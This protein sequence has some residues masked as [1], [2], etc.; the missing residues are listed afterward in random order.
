M[1]QFDKVFLSILGILA[2]AFC[3]I[4]GTIAYDTFFNKSI[5]NRRI[6]CVQGYEFT[7]DSTGHFHQIIDK[8][9]NGIPCTY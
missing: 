6:I 2:I 1:D 3:V 9:G 4:A 7:I 8:T 5:S